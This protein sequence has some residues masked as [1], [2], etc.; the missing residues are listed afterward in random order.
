VCTVAAIFRSFT[1]IRAG[2]PKIQLPLL[3]LHGSDD[4]PAD[5][6]GS[7]WLMAEVGSIDKTRKIYP[8]CYHELFLEP[9]KQQVQADLV[10]W[11]K[12]HSGHLLR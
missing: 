12:N 1:Q 11:L 6:A 3:I 5:P 2:R 9:E 8:G 4:A 7:E 10:A